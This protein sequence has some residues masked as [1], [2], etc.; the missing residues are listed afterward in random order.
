M[1]DLGL[2]LSAAWSVNM[3]GNGK[4]AVIMQLPVNQ[5]AM[6]MNIIWV[7][8]TF[9][10]SSRARFNSIYDYIGYRAHT[11]SIYI[12][13]YICRQTNVIDKRVDNE[14]QCILNRIVELHMLICIFNDMRQ[15]CSIDF[16]GITLSN[17]CAK[18]H[19]FIPKWTSGWV[20]EP[21]MYNALSRRHLIDVD[22]SICAALE[23]MKKSRGT[24]NWSVKIVFFIL[25]YRV[26][27][28]C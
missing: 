6:T 27:V 7:N 13:I 18:L 3:I 10:L 9:F 26:S 14:L 15:K 28:S 20:K 23:N 24:R 22:P 12:Y 8:T 21:T 4:R 16:N 19:S 17:A 2:L 1:F 5:T 11:L 25:I